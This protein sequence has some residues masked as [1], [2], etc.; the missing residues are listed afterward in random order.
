MLV[1]QRLKKHICV[2]FNKYSDINQQAGGFLYGNE[3][4]YHISVQFQDAAPSK[5]C[6][7]NCLSSWNIPI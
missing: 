5:I 3:F 4:S 6:L 7:L 1:N 2:C